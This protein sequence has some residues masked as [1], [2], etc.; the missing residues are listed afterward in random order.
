MLHCPVA[1]AGTVP[2]RNEALAVSQ[3][4]TP[5]NLQMMP[6]RECASAWAGHEN[7]RRW[8]I[9]RS[10]TICWLGLPE[11]TRAANMTKRNIWFNNMPYLLALQLARESVLLLHSTYIS[12]SG[13]AISSTDTRQTLYWSNLCTYMRVSLWVVQPTIRVFAA[14]PAWYCPPAFWG[15]VIFGDAQYPVTFPCYS[16]Q[17]ALQGESDWSK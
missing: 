13:E 11:R 14:Y 16:P 4:G 3:A 17:Q 2:M 10:R 15:L 12:H 8:S 9:P 7:S 1:S 6:D 5:E